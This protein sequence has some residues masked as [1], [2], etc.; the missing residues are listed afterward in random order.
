MPRRK[1]IKTPVTSDLISLAVYEPGFFSTF[2]PHRPFEKWAAVEVLNF[3]QVPA[4]LETFVLPSGLYAVFHYQGL[5]GDPR[6]FEFIF[7][8]WL[9]RS[10][11]ELDDR[12]HFEVLGEK[13]KNQDPSS[14]EDLYIPVKL[15]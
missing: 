8:T 4:G 14:E 11:Y 9:P 7:G 13:Y 1:E 2:Q 12:P 15:K 10:Q 3:D 6:V 5:S